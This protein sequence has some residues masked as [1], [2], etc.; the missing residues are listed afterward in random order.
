MW[1]NEFEVTH[2]MLQL[3]TV[4]MVMDFLQEVQFAAAY[5]FNSGWCPPVE[6]CS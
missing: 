3:V 6:K 2:L 4:N 1:T 5:V